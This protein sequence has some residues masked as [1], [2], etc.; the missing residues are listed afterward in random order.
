MTFFGLIP[1]RL[2]TLCQTGI[3]GGLFRED[4]RALGLFQRG[5]GGLTGG[6]RLLALMDGEEDSVSWKIIFRLRRSFSQVAKL[7]KDCLYT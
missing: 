7:E 6:G 3:R 4:L 1:T 5:S 2:K